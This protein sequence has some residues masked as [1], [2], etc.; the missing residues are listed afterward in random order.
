MQERNSPKDSFAD[1]NERE[2][3]RILQEEANQG[4]WNEPATQQP[5][6]DQFNG[7][8]LVGPGGVRQADEHR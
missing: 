1:E 5:S 3:A 2:I 7:A 8:N 6:R 4:V